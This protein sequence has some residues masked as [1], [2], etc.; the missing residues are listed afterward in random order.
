MVLYKCC[1]H[2]LSHTAHTPRHMHELKSP[3][4][5]WKL[6]PL[7]VPQF[8][9]KELHT[10]CF[11]Q[12]Y[13]MSILSLSLSHSAKKINFPKFLF[14]C[15]IIVLIKLYGKVLFENRDRIL[16]ILFIQWNFNVRF[17]TRK[18]C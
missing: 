15:K 5:H 18:H 13:A 2:P 3:I 17:A 7:F 9:V 10:H 4:T 11:Y 12:N 14:T 1:P 8:L 16:L 6:Y